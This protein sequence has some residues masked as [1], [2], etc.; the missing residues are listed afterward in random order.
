M[1]ENEVKLVSRKGMEL[2]MTES[3]TGS[4]VLTGTCLED[5]RLHRD[6]H[7]SLRDIYLPFIS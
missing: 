4:V 5:V 3:S 2:S 1:T 7:R 6:L